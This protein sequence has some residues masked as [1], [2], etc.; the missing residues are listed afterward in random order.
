MFKITRNRSWNRFFSI[1]V[2]M[3]LIVAVNI[4]I[5]YAGNFT[6]KSGVTILP[7]GPKPTKSGVTILPIGPK[8][9]KSGVTILPIGPKPTRSDI[10]NLPDAPR[11]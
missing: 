11:P 5:S 1:L 8:P 3:L 2:A 4:A 7:I 6:Q 10:S 9:T